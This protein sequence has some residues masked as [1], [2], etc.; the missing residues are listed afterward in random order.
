M[1]IISE[2][3]K[4]TFLKEDHV[5]RQEIDKLLE[6]DEESVQVCGQSSITA[7]HMISTTMGSENNPSCGG[8]RCCNLCQEQYNENEDTQ[9]S[10]FKKNN[11]R[12][13][14]RLQES[15]PHRHDNDIRDGQASKS[16]SN[17]NDLD[18][19]ERCLPNPHLGYRNKL[20]TMHSSEIRERVYTSSISLRKFITILLINS[21]LSQLRHKAVHQDSQWNLINSVFDPI[22][23]L[24]P[25]LVKA[26]GEFHRQ[27]T[28][29]TKQYS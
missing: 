24:T 15:L 12:Y 7:D 10:R 6:S 16:T 19:V 8:C 21:I 25:A 5:K 11:G 22:D 17:R 9:H 26:E 27:S 1:N 2:Q 3:L 4:N 13:D 28:S 23:L 20:T 14:N 29:S 18:L